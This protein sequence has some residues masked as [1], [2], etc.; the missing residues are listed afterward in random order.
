MIS[1]KWYVSNFTFYSDLPLLCPTLLLRN[2]SRDLT[3]GVEE[4]RGS[5][6]DFQPTRIDIDFDRSQLQVA[7]APLTIQRRNGT[8]FSEHKYFS[9]APLRTQTHIDLVK[10]YEE[11]VRAIG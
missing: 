11:Y 4:I 10:Q 8:P 3:K 2:L 9:E 1:R 6:F 5:R 7:M